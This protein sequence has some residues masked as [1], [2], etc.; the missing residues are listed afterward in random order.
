[1]ARA[2]GVAMNRVP[3][4][5]PAAPNDNAAAS[6]D[7]RRSPGGDNGDRP[8][9]GVDDQGHERQRRH[10]AGV[11]TSL[12]ALGD[13]EVTPGVERALGVFDLAA[14]R[15]D[16]DAV[17][18]AKVDDVRGTPSPTTKVLAPPSISSSTLCLRVSGNAV[19]RSTPKG[20]VVS[21]LVAAI[22]CERRSL[23]IVEARDSRSPRRWRPRRERAVGDAAHAREH[24]RVFDVQHLGESRFHWSPFDPN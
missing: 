12:G 6:L 8:G 9:H 19:K 13:D 20:L 10:R 23:D 14:H 18:V 4:H 2:S 3:I 22:S 15:N 21:S 16:E 11:T 24:H 17:F 7:R 5:T 1:M